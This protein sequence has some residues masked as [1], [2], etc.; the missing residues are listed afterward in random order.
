MDQSSHEQ[1][2]LPNNGSVERNQLV[3]WLEIVY[4]VRKVISGSENR[5][6]PRS[7]RGRL[8]CMAVSPFLRSATIKRG[9][10]G[11]REPTF[12]VSTVPPQ[13][14]TTKTD[15][16]GTEARGLAR[17]ASNTRPPT[18]VLRLRP[19]PTPCLHPLQPKVHS[20]NP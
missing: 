8:S 1:S 16:R 14:L 19:S 2:S 13:T 12:I 18:A 11:A 6:N 20:R 3:Q 10:T 4:S 15:Q 9:Q 5:S 7:D 17:L